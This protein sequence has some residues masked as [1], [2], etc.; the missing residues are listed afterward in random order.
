[1]PATVTLSTTA[2]TNGINPRDQE[3]RL[4]SYSGILPGYRLFVDRELMTV[5]SVR[6]D[7]NGVD[8]TRGVDGTA[9]TDH[10]SSAVVTIGKADQFYQ[11]DP[12]GAP[13]GAIEVSPYINTR[14][15]KV[16]Y[17]QGDSQPTG[18]TYRWWQDVTQTYGFGP[19]GIRTQTAAPTSST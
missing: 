12:Q 10:S 19:L 3:F 16:F 1:M 13:A 18:V 5:V 9:A 2:L 14:N 15:G 7:S 8:V 6:S 4:N 17:A 11:S